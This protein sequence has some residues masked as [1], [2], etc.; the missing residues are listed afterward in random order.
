MIIII[1]V[2]LV[3]AINIMITFYIGALDDSLRKATPKYSNNTAS[4]VI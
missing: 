4:T 2:T 1:H 3:I